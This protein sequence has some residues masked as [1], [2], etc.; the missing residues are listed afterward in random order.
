MAYRIQ[1][2]KDT[3]S[4]WNVVG[5][6]SGK[7]EAVKAVKQMKKQHPSLMLCVLDLSTKDPVL[8]I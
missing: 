8:S 2:K 1:Y 3:Y 6:T 5:T 7:N 4:N